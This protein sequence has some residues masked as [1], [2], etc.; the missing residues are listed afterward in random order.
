PSI[1]LESSCPR[2][3]L[4]FRR[5]RQSRAK[6]SSEMTVEDAVR[7]KQQPVSIAEILGRCTQHGITLSLSGDDLK[8]AS[9]NGAIRGDIAVMLRERKADIVRF[10]ASVAGVESRRSAIESLSDRN[11]L[12]LSYA[13]QRMWFLNQYTGPSSVYNISLALRLSAS[14]N[15][16]ALRRALE[17]IHARHE[18]L[19][20]RFESQGGEAVQI[21]DAPS[22]QVMVEPVAS[23]AQVMSI[24]EGERA[25]PFDLA[26]QSPCRIRLLQ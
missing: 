21:I 14:L 1:E 5:G 8:A 16:D 19:R 13:Q 7:P 18:V 23:G 24:S 12:P 2:I 9:V 6:K 10:L 11:S 15:V 3:H 17:T 25:H 26:A 22:L 4:C 20:A